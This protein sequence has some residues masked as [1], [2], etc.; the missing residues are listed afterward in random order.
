MLISNQASP[1]IR[2]TA[3]RA[4]SSQTATVQDVVD[5][6]FSPLDRQLEGWIELALKKP[7]SAVLAL[8]NASRNLDLT[9]GQ[10]RAL[11]SL[12]RKAAEIG[13][14]TRQSAALR[15]GLV[16][17][18][19]MAQPEVT[20]GALGK[21]AYDLVLG[22]QDE[23]EATRKVYLES[24]LDTLYSRAYADG[25]VDLK[26]TMPE[27]T[28][29]DDPVFM[30]SLLRLD[31]DFRRLPPS[32]GERL[33]QQASSFSLA[34]DDKQ[35]IQATLEMAGKPMTPALTALTAPRMEVV[36]HLQAHSALAVENLDHERAKF[37]RKLSQA[38]TH[39][40]GDTLLEVT[41]RCRDA[42]SDFGFTPL[43]QSEQRWARSVRAGN[44]VATC[45]GMAATAGATLGICLVVP[46]EGA[47]LVGILGAMAGLGAAC[48]GSQRLDDTL[49]EAQSNRSWIPNSITL[50]ESTIIEAFNKPAQGVGKGASIPREAILTVARGDLAAQNDSRGVR[51]QQEL[52]AQLEALPG[53]TAAEMFEQAF[54]A[55]FDAHPDSPSSLMEAVKNC[56]LRA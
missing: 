10:R 38:V 21:A 49:R 55:W 45:L 25:S 50:N 23:P 40:E 2:T 32:I 39:V 5:I 33:T 15:G 34:A 12:Q 47:M 46:P 48:L 36:K 3:S 52:I 42:Y 53:E 20:L 51:S 13:S 7:A 54:L 4:S 22:S 56:A 27:L 19:H 43:N 1:P 28:S 35:R 37:Y 11:R 26:V 8:E 24:G 14:S 17:L 9:R 44:T 18:K 30:A 16:A 29:C 6:Q 41:R 31:P